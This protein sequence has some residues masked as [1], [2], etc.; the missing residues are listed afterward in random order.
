MNKETVMKS[1]YLSGL[2][3]FLILLAWLSTGWSGPLERMEI[4]SSPNPVGSGARALGMGGAYIG[5]ANDATAASWNPAGIG[6][7]KKSEISMV[8]HYI[9]R[10]EDNEINPAFGKGDSETIDDFNLNYLSAA[11]VIPQ[12]KN[13]VV[14]SLNYQQLFDFNREWHMP[15]KLQNANTIGDTT[16][17][18]VQ[19]GEIY[20]MGFAVGA[21]LNEK[22]F[23]G[24]TINDWGNLF[25]NRWKQSHLQTGK[26]QIGPNEGISNAQKNETYQMDGINLNLGLIGKI[27][28]HIQVGAVL[29]TPFKANL[30][31]ERSL[32]ISDTF[33]DFPT[34]NQYQ[35]NQREYEC[36]LRMPL[37]YGLGAAYIDRQHGWS[38]SADIYRTHWN[39]FEMELTDGRRISPISGLD[40]N[41]ADVD[42]T[43]WIRCGGQKSFQLTN[44]LLEMRAGIFYDPAPAEH[45]P[46]DFWG[47]S[48]GGGIGNEMFTIDVAYQVRFGNDVGDSILQDLDF[49]QDIVDHKFFVSFIYYLHQ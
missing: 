22:L 33:P 9:L 5:L 19:E 21:Q 10:S 15:V 38:F 3:T 37:S 14:V 35:A 25:Y 17:D 4:P 43:I 30:D 12:Q 20:A 29:K 44:Y 1:Y 28:S 39:Q 31:L 6:Q 48:L 40:M 45:S 11:F 24:I 27:T 7:L 23:A 47:M 32:V 2:I 36:H 34:A 8:S 49:S 26:F 18:M 41:E 16:Y 46:D 42:P 13:N